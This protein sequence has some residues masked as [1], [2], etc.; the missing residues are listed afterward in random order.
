M[1]RLECA[2][3][4]RS[5]S[6][7]LGLELNTRAI[8]I[9]TDFSILL[10]RSNSQ[11]NLVSR[12][13]TDKVI[14]RHMLES[15]ALVPLLTTQTIFRTLTSL[16]VLDVG[17]GCGALGIVLSIVMPNHF[18]FSSETCLKKNQFQVQ[19][20]MMFKLRNYTITYK[21][22]QDLSALG[23]DVIIS[24]AFHQPSRL[25]EILDS[26]KA[27]AGLLLTMAGHYPYGSLKTLICS[28]K[29]QHINILKT[30][31]WLVNKSRHIILLRRT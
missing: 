3:A 18:F 17:S 7:L 27:P 2:N 25:V 26:N 13:T 14:M 6:N 11:F 22:I 15:L 29:L 28:M 30:K 10:L 12:R 5:C 24:K 4:L 1:L 9:I 8:T 19:T 23:V 16:R 21:R 20:K 31:V